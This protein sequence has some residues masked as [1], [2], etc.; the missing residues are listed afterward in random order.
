LPGGETNAVEFKSTLRT[1]LH[2]GLVDDKIQVSALKTIAG[3]MN[4]K[5]GTLLVGVADD[6]EVLGLTSDGF[7]NGDKLQLHL[8]GLIRDRIGDVFRHTSIL[9]FRTKMVFVCSQSIAKRGQNLRLSKTATYSVF[10]CGVAM[11]PL[12]CRALR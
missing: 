11:R 7:E 12:T 2:T 8:V 9:I 3:F 10:L 4:A 5:G 1:N 6:G